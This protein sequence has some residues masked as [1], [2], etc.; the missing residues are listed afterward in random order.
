[1]K[2]F[3]LKSFG[4]LLLFVVAFAGTSFAQEK[5]KKVKKKVV[6]VTTTTDEN[7]RTITKKVVKENGEVKETEITEILKE[8]EKDGGEIKV[9]VTVDEN[10]ENEDIQIIQLDNGRKKTYEIK[11]K[12]DDV[13]V[14]EGASDGKVMIIKGDKKM[15]SKDGNVFIFKSKLH[16]SK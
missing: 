11:I 2:N 10:G 13:E 1:M 14:E 4:L 12:G 5:D 8:V 3:T 6:K 9:N 15:K 7:G 16:S